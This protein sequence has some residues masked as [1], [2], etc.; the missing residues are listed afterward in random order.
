VCD[1]TMQKTTFDDAKLYHS[2]LFGP[3]NN[4]KII[5]LFKAF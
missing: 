1:V 3:V 4:I 2:V 5:K